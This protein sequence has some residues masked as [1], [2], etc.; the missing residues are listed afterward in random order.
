MIFGENDEIREREIQTG[1][2]SSSNEESVLNE[3]LL[4]RLPGKC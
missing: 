1:E 3:F 4:M 2:H